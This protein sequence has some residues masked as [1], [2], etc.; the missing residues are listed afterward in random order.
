M[1]IAFSFS[2]EDEKKKISIQFSFFKKM[3]FN[4][5]SLPDTQI[6][7]HAGAKRSSR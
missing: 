2:R 1:E 7:L 3:K 4:F 6:L 5:S